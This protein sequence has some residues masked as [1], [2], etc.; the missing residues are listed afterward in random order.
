MLQQ[1]EIDNFK[2]SLVIGLPNTTLSLCY[3]N[4]LC[5]NFILLELFASTLI[6]TSGTLKKKQISVTA[7]LGQPL[8]RRHPKPESS[9]PA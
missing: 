9:K 3:R 6:Y 7:P 5:V 4:I 1:L 2:T 8:I